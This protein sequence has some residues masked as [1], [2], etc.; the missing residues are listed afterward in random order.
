MATWT[1]T[2]AWKSGSAVLPSRQV[3]RIAPGEI[4]KDPTVPAGASNQAVALTLA[5]ADIKGIFLVSSA[6][7]TLKTNSSSSPTQTIALKAG[8]PLVWDD[9][10][11]FACPISADITGT[12]YLSNAGAQDAEVDIRFLTAS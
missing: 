3:A 8:R 6:D 4:T 5:V 7:V 12:I 10:D 11:Y 9:Q 1:L 2:K